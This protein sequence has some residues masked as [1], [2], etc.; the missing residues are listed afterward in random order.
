MGYRDQKVIRDTRDAKAAEFI[1]A[2][3]SAFKQTVAQGQK[4]KQEEQKELKDLQTK[5]Q[6]A[7][8][9]RYKQMADFKKTGSKALD[10]QVMAEIEKAAREESDLYMKAF[11]NDGTPE[12]IA[13]Y[14]KLVATNNR[15]LNDLTM[16]IGTF[17][18]DVDA[19]ANAIANGSKLLPGGGDFAFEL[20]VQQGGP[21]EL[22]KGKDGRYSIYGGAGGNYAGK[23]IKLG[24][25]HDD[26]KK[27]GTRY[28]MVDDDYNLVMDEWAKGIIENRDAFSGFSQKQEIK[29][30]VPIGSGKT[31][32]QEGV[33]G[34]FF[35][36]M[37]YK[38]DIVDKLNKQSKQTPGTV[39]AS[40]TGGPSLSNEQMYMTLRD[41]LPVIKDFAGNDVN[42]IDIS[43][44]DYAYLA[45][46]N[47]ALYTAFADYVIDEGTYMRSQPKDVSKSNVDPTTAAAGGVKTITQ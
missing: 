43:Y 28:E 1:G 17:D 10:E 44:E 23:E 15:D 41:R 12:L 42:P 31:T 36:P 6:S 26:F 9:G 47:D 27:N 32:K 20:D 22:K 16:F 34:T 24:Q 3:G 8:S 39:T 7:V 11:G 30:G 40:V 25:Y 5:A 38:E 35:D 4:R 33:K 46:N 37:A 2:A 13:D 14:Q 29:G 18:Q 45:G 21:V 19:A